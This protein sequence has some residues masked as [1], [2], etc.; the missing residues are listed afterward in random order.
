MSDN[1]DN[2]LNTYD[3]EQEAKFNWTPK[4]K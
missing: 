1:S 4:V 3:P 2:E